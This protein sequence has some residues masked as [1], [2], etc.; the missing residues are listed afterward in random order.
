MSERSVT[1]TLPINSCDPRSVFMLISNVHRL[2]GWHFRTRVWICCTGPHSHSAHDSRSSCFSNS[3]ALRKVTR[4]ECLGSTALGVISTMNFTSPGSVPVAL[5]PGE[6]KFMVE[7]TDR[8]STRLNSSHSQ[9][10]YA[11]FCLKKKKHNN[12][13]VLMLRS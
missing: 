1:K 2:P 11:V 6:V 5:H 7:I 3:P 10:S 9:I 8:K 4:A 12:N 13:R